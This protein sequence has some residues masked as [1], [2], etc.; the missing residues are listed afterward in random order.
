MIIITDYQS[1]VAS[2]L[3]Y[4]HLRMS[5]N[6]SFYPDGSSLVGF[7]LACVLDEV[8]LIWYGYEFLDANSLIRR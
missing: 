2:G 4:H 6:V 7:I 3:K 1:T 8:K 5:K